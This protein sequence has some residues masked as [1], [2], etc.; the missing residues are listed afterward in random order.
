V[1][2]NPKHL[3]FAAL[4]I[5]VTFDKHEI[6]RHKLKFVLATIKAAMREAWAIRRLQ[7]Y[8]LPF[9]IYCILVPTV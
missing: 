6:K 1:P 2:A 8:W 9:F 3:G 5:F 4:Q 7:Q